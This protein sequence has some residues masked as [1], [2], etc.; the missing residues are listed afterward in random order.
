MS[1]LKES[2]VQIFEE[3]AELFIESSKTDQHQY[4]AWVVIARTGKPTCPVSM[5]KRYMSM[6][7]IVGSHERF[8]FRGTYCEH[9]VRFPT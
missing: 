4:G 6:G 3:H 1:R 5:L 7:G 9:Q 2:D 8:L